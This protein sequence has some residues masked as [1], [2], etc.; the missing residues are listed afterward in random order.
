MTFSERIK[1]IDKKLTETTKDV[2]FSSWF[3]LLLYML[4]FYLIDFFAFFTIFPSRNVPVELYFGR[5]SISYIILL[6]FFIFLFPKKVSMV[7]FG[8]TSVFLLCYEFAQMCYASVNKSLFRFSIITAAKDGMNFAG[9]ALKAVPLKIYAGYGGLLLLIALFLFIIGK[10]SKEPH[11]KFSKKFKLFGSLTGTLFACIYTV[12]II[13]WFL[14]SGTMDNY[15]SY[16]Y[17]NYTNLCDTVKMFKRND[18]IML[19]DRDIV[20]SITSRMNEAK[21]RKEIKDFFAEKTPHSDNEM[22][23]IFKGKNLII[24]QLETFEKQL[25]TEELCPNIYELQQK[26]IE[27]SNFYSARFGDTYTFGT[28]LAVNTGLFAPSGLDIDRSIVNNA[29]PYSAANLFRKLGYSANEFHYNTP[30][31]YNRGNM[32]KTFGYE[33]YI[34]YIDYAENKERIFELDDVLADDDGLYD[35]LIKN[36]HYMDFVVSFSAHLPYVTDDVVYEEAVKRRPEL[37]TSDPSDEKAIYFAKATI[38]D[39][40]VGKLMERFEEDGVLDNTV[41]IFY[42]DHYNPII[43]PDD[44]TDEEYSNTPC[45]IYCKGIE[46]MVVDKYCSTQ[47]L[48]PTLVNMFDLGSCDNYIAEDIF[49]PN[50]EGIVYFQNLAWINDKYHFDGTEVT[51]NY[52]DSEIDKNYVSKINEMVKKRIDVNNHILFFDYY[53]DDG[54]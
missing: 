51:E 9:T 52:T 40:M 23:G 31:F 45:F 12:F 54:E 8:I 33:N 30:G 26:S 5:V 16:D 25:I 32:H 44:V 6:S 43:K 22:T 1:A 14:S 2:K 4:T 39:D 17:Y 19:A 46:H 28:E 47:N 7:I 29:L 20:C 41:L 3:P 35:T 10:F 48:L 34:R 15:G 50:Y 11:T 27:F 37:K 49:D 53:N 24:F 38:T 13:P 18:L 42:G 21:N 36:D